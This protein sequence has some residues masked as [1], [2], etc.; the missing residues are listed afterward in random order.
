[1]SGF[2]ASVDSS[3]VEREDR[4]SVFLVGRVRQSPLEVVA[5]C[6]GWTNVGA[7]VSY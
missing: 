1:M 2:M 6:P 7:R 4:Q 5:A 3:N